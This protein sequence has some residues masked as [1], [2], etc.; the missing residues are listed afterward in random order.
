MDTPYL[1]AFVMSHRTDCFGAEV[2]DNPQGR[3]KCIPIKRRDTFLLSKNKAQQGEVRGHPRSGPLPVDF[4]VLSKVKLLPSVCGLATRL[5]GRVRETSCDINTIGSAG[6][7]QPRKNIRIYR[8]N[9]GNFR[10]EWQKF[11]SLK[12]RKILEKTGN[13]MEISE[14]YAPT[15]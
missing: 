9:V 12:F 13:L 14:K 1:L 3:A 2:A 6:V 4:W 5:A 15:N 7:R 10:Y 11:L 8:E